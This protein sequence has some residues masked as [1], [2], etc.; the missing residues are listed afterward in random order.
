MNL[1]DCLQW[2]ASKCLCTRPKKNISDI[3]FTPQY[4]I[5]FHKRYTFPA[6]LI[7]NIMVEYLDRKSATALSFTSKSNF[8]IACFSQG[9]IKAYQKATYGARK[10]IAEEII[11]NKFWNILIIGLTSAKALYQGINILSKT[12][13]YNDLLSHS[14]A[15]VNAFAAFTDY[16]TDYGPLDDKR[17]SIYRTFDIPE[18]FQT[19]HIPLTYLKNSVAAYIFNKNGKTNWDEH[20]YDAIVASGGGY[21]TYLSRELFSTFAVWSFLACYALLVIKKL[22]S[23]IYSPELPSLKQTRTKHS[24][25]LWN[26]TQPKNALTKEHKQTPNK[27]SK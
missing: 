13:T 7:E 23:P 24:F 12:H 4:T 18:N 3:D 17:L 15:A 19:T 9:G 6:D 22:I 25:S 16:R 20:S 11:D 21:E 27:L 8:K 26:Q 14:H 2:F 1:Y 10:A 5:T